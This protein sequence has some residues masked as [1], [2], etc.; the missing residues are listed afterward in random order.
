M[1][2]YTFI[3]GIA[4]YFLMIKVSASTRIRPIT[5]SLVVVL[6]YFSL[7][8]FVQ[9]IVLSAYNAPLWQLFGLV[10]LSTALLQ[11]G[12]AFIVFYKLD[13]S[14]DSYGSWLAWG[15]LGCI[16]IFFVAPIIATSLFIRF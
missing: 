14:N 5:A 11:L 16:G 3:A 13:Q 4:L 7:H 8:A 2:D 10:P 15:A 9:G 6:S 12:V 1:V